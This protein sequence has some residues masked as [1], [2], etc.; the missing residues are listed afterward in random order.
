MRDYL[1]RIQLKRLFL[2]IGLS[3][4]LAGS[5]NVVTLCQPVDA[6]VAVIQQI[7]FKANSNQLEIQTTHPVSASL[8]PFTDT[9]QQHIILDI[10]GSRAGQNFPKGSVLLQQLKNVWPE[11]TAF[12]IR[13]FG[14]TS[15]TTRLIFTLP[16]ESPAPVLSQ[17][18]GQSIRLSVD[19]AQN[20]AQKNTANQHVRLSEAQ[21]ELK[22][23]IRVIQLQ[24]KQI[25]AL[26]E[27]F[28]KTGNV[29]EYSAR[30]QISYLNTKLTEKEQEVNTLKKQLAL[31]GQANPVPDQIPD[32]HE[33]IHYLQLQLSE[34]QAENQQLAQQLAQAQTAQQTL[35]PATSSNSSNSN[36]GEIEQLKQRIQALEQKNQLLKGQL[37]EALELNLSRIGQVKSQHIS[38]KSVSNSKKANALSKK[39]A[40]ATQEASQLRQQ[41][42]QLKAQ[43]AS[44][45][46][47]S[48]QTAE[49]STRL[50]VE[51]AAVI[52][53]TEA[54]K[55]Y[56]AGKAFEAQGQFGKARDAYQQAASQ[57]TNVPEYTLAY[58]STLLRLKAYDQ[59]IQTVQAFQKNNTNAP[60]NR[61]AYNHLGKAYLLK[62]NTAMAEQAFLS[63][64]HEGALSNY[65]TTLKRMG[66]LAKAE[67]VLKL[68]LELNPKDTDLLFNLGNLYNK[69]NQ[70]PRAKQAYEEAIAIK[71][72]FAEAHYN[73]GLVY[74][75]L[76][77]SD[78]AVSHL[79][80]YLEL[81]PQA[82]NHQ[83]IRSYIQRLK[84]G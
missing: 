43:I 40:M 39:L 67:A 46:N 29:L 70:L 16:A 23:A 66:N 62:G 4:A 79:Q 53:P 75:K 10:Q 50:P 55:F 81:T 35:E 54:Q 5:F 42:T 61:E 65:A 48:T 82:K 60:T 84:Q 22:K 80:T 52:N 17:A 18:S 68:S 47:A 28:G 69:Q 58:T 59:V 56:Q 21:Q 38:T 13:Q 78:T 51:A 45:Q 76:G 31:T 14:E 41:V 49:P 64:L 72:N 83:A 25:A 74:A 37:Q 71:P 7:G 8:H 11:L 15:P 30:D 20:T 19:T 33:E 63:A 24:K 3:A 2:A 73:L 27:K 36:D 57:A 34:K 26:K 1:Q 32:Q 6:Q 12:N 77:S 9:E 44:I